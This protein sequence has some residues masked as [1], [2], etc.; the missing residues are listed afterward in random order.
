M[1]TSMLAVFGLASLAAAVPS[2]LE[3]RQSTANDLT[4]G[5]CKAVTL[6]FARGTT[7][8]GNLVSLEFPRLYILR[9]R[10]QITLHVRAESSLGRWS[11]S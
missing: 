1:K 10:C 6:I 5:E 4:S 2:E 7:E 8:P 9:E 11:E 3:R